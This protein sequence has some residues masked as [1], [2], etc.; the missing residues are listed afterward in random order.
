MIDIGCG[1]IVVNLNNAIKINREKIS[2]NKHK[3]MKINDNIT[4][5]K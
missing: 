5:N 3:S 4:S 2:K 1:D